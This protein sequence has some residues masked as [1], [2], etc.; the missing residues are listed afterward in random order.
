MP[1]TEEVELIEQAKPFVSL[2]ASKLAQRRLKNAQFAKLAKVN[3]TLFCR[4]MARQRPPEKNLD[5][6]AKVLELEGHERLEFLRL[7]YLAR[8]N[9]LLSEIFEQQRKEIQRLR[10]ALD[11]T[12]GGSEGK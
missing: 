1:N 4:I 2:L 6:W 9:P 7:G 10:K 5:N 11:A 12:G 8:A 3:D